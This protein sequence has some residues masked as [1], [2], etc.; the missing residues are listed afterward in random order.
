VVLSLRTESRQWQARLKRDIWLG[1]LAR[2]IS[3][4][5]W[6]VL[7]NAGEALRRQGRY[8]EA[9]LFFDEASALQRGSGAARYLQ[10]LTHGVLLG[11]LLGPR[12]HVDPGAGVPPVGQPFH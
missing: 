10:G 11:G 6:R 2:V 9:R 1:H 8:R 7:L 4:N 12:E 5:W 3:A